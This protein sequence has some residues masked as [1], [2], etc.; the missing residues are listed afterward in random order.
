M[1]PSLGPH[2]W[3]L[4]AASNRAIN[5]VTC[6]GEGYL[7]WTYGPWSLREYDIFNAVFIN[8]RT[9]PGASPGLERYNQGLSAAHE[10]GHFFGLLHT[11]G[12]S[13]SGCG[14]DDHDGDHVTDT[15][16]ERVPQTECTHSRDSCPNDPG[17]DPSW[18]FMDY[19]PDACMQRFSAGQV[20]R[21]RAMIMEYKPRL[22]GTSA[23]V[24]TSA[25]NAR[26]TCEQIT[27]G[28]DCQGECGWSRKRVSCV[29]GGKTN[30]AELSLG[31]GCSAAEPTA[32][33]PSPPTVPPAVG[34]PMTKD[35]KR[36]QKL[37]CRAIR[38][39]LDCTG[40]CGWSTSKGK[41][42]FNGRT[43][44]AEQLL[45]DGCGNVPVPEDSSDTGGDRIGED[46]TPGPEMTGQR[47]CID[48]GWRTVPSIGVCGASRFDGVCH[49]RNS[50]YRD[51]WEVC[52]VAGGRL[53]SRDELD[54]G[55]SVGTGC[56]LNGK[57]VWSSSACVTSGGLPGF[58]V[59]R[60]QADGSAEPFCEATISRTRH[61]VRCCSNV[62]LNGGPSDGARLEAGTTV[63]TEAEGMSTGSVSMIVGI[64]LAVLGA[65][66][67]VYHRK[68]AT[69]TAEL[70]AQI[71][72]KTE[73][74]GDWETDCETD[75]SASE[76]GWSNSNGAPTV[77]SSTQETSHK[78]A[79]TGVSAASGG[80]SS[81]REW[82]TAPQY[83]GDCVSNGKLNGNPLYS[84]D[85]SDASSKCSERTT[86][87]VERTNPL[88]KNISD[89]PA[90]PAP[91][92]GH[93]VHLRCP[94]SRLRQ[95]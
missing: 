63:T 66:F 52:T 9:F 91:K 47:S 2:I 14:D 87:K 75:L 70:R 37:I 81:F 76:F 18:S 65:V 3:C 39:G 93:P 16:I 8:W 33:E 80:D 83:P 4:P 78:R 86:S 73:F 59:G 30:N 15:P 38:C 57:L 7:G 29:R 35:E 88:C 60:G 61:S 62:F 49:V 77:L 26:P 54:D 5:I 55:A 22:S 84:R 48:L 24:T 10:M 21:M 27:C 36:A 6:S 19:T 25:N 69:A 1:S 34:S 67:A 58:L 94:T 43:S 72:C 42:I 32:N 20:T 82:N 44:K 85:M 12:G 31:P 40:L 41:C 28:A 68:N 53:C 50:V 11:F 79:L 17:L 46:P 56:G 71:G 64:M 13:S 51:A 90:H 23:V 95:L 74:T 45:G 89:P 92:F